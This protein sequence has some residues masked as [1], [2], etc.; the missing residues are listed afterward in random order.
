MSST[1][2]TT[3]LALAGMAATPW[4]WHQ[5]RNTRRSDLSARS[6]FRL[7]ALLAVS[8]NPANCSATSTSDAAPAKSSIFGIRLCIWH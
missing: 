5:V 1:K 8:K 6:V 4:C 3:L 7:K 2:A